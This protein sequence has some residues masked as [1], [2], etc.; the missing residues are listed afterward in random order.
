MTHRDRE[1]AVSFKSIRAYANYKYSIIVEDLTVLNN[2]IEKH[3]RRAQWLSN[4]P[5]SAP[6]N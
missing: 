6:H 5:L 3:K 4:S 1:S 2:E